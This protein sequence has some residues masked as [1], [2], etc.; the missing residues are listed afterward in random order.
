M[1]AESL[2]TL[3]RELGILQKNKFLSGFL[4]GELAVRHESILE[5]EN[6]SPEGKVE[7]LKQIASFTS[8]F[9]GGVN[10]VIDFAIKQ[11]EASAR[12][13]KNQERDF[14]QQTMKSRV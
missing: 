14:T 12:K 9:A 1:K 2:L 10:D 13:P 4:M 5:N 7:A 3:K 6:I 11:K 8:L